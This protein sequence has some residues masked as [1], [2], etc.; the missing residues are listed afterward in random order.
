MYKYEYIGKLKNELT[1]FIK[2]IS[3]IK[4]DPYKLS[5]SSKLI[6]QVS[7]K[8][9]LDKIL[10]KDTNYSAIYNINTYTSFDGKTM[11]SDKSVQDMVQQYKHNN[12]KNLFYYLVNKNT[13]VKNGSRISPEIPIL[14]ILDLLR[15]PIINTGF[16]GFVVNIL[17]DLEENKNIVLN[18]YKQLFKKAFSDMKYINYSRINSCFNNKYLIIEIFNLNYGPFNDLY[19]VNKST[20]LIEC[21]IKTYKKVNILNDNT[22]IVG[23]VRGEDVYNE[24]VHHCQIK[25]I[26]DKL[27]KNIYYTRYCLSL[28]HYNEDIYLNK[29]KMAQ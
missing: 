16:Y 4:D 8:Q 10:I 14:Q 7:K 20:N 12:D 19:I 3:E 21:F 22:I 23:I 17:V 18:F 9:I 25:L 28:E 15:K 2:H 6:N 26:N 13:L 24:Y 27:V 1:C 5:K 29:N 11:I